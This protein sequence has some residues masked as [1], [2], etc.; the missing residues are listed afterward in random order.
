MEIR[1][2]KKY[3]KMSPQ[4]IRVVVEM[5]KD[6]TPAQALEVLPHLGKRAADP[7][8]ETIK[9]AVH[10]AKVKG[11][12]EADLVFKEIQINEGPRLKRGR[13][14]ARGRWKPYIRKMSHIRVV[15][16]TKKGNKKDEPKS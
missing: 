16:E 5:V 7:L 8:A 4:K 11:I 13:A 2:V 3:I 1:A 9:S 10:N 15:L 14:G 6:L 12:S